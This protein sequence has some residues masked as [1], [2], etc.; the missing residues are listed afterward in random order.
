MSLNVMIV[1]DTA[2]I[3]SDGVSGSILRVARSRS[4]A[5]KTAR[6]SNRLHGLNALEPGL[7]INSAPHKPSPVA[8]QRRQPTFSLRK[9]AAAAVATNGL[10][11]STAVTSANGSRPSAVWKNTAPPV[12]PA[13]RN[14]MYFDNAS[15]RL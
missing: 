11:C 7:M 14:S 2:M 4:V 12:S 6:I 15:F 3:S 10:I 8:L 5:E 13:A 9:I 1:D